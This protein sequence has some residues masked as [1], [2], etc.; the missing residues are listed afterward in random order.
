MTRGGTAWATLCS[1]PWRP[2]SAECVRQSDTV[3]RTGG[4]EILVLLPGVQSL[5]Q[6]AQI[7][8]K[9]R[10]RAS[11]PIHE[12][13]ITIHATLSIGATIALP[14]EPV[15]SITARADAAMYDAKSADRNTVIK[16]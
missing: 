6:A 7:A 2:G 16:I 14:G 15:S 1:Q 8:E 11:E 12:S 3:G 4:D 5:E 13:G 9:I 10:Y